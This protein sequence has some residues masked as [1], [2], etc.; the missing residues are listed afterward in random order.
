MK[1]VL[2]FIIVLS[3][4]FFSGT[5]IAMLGLKVNDPKGALKSIKLKA[6]SHEDETI[7]YRTQN[8][9]DLSV[10]VDEDKIVMME[11][12]RVPGAEG[13]EP[14]FSNFKFGKTSL[15]DIRKA[16]GSNGYTYDQRVNMTTDSE[17]IEFNCFEFD[18]PN[19]EVLVTIT[20]ASLDQDL[21]GDKIPQSL[22]LDGIIIADAQFMEA[23]WGKRK[24]YASNYKKITADEL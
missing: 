1:T 18:S 16:C 7:K 13:D 24:H 19:N 2:S 10:T 6:V 8:G 20:K 22:K 23:I 3:G 14:L 15:A 12:D 4:V 21:S 5:D 9:N 17:L 11:N